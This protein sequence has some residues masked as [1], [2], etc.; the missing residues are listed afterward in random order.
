[1]IRNILLMILIFPILTGIQLTSAA[2]STMKENTTENISVSSIRSDEFSMNPDVPVNLNKY[3][4]DNIPHKNKSMQI[5]VTPS[6]G[7][8]LGGCGE[9]GY[10]VRISGENFGNGWDIT[11]VTICGI[12]VCQI[13]MQSSDIVIVYPGAGTPGTGDIVITSKSMGKTTIEKAFTYE[14]STPSKESKNSK[15]STVSEIADKTR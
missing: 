8:Y 3:V 4:G 14:N 9:D 7:S 2:R 12:E 13:I 1:M 10:H 15:Y 6:I 5:K 11:S